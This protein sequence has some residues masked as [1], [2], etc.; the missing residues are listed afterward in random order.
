MWT[1]LLLMQDLPPLYHVQQVT[2]KLLEPFWRIW[3]LDLCCFALLLAAFNSCTLLALVY[4]SLCGVGMLVAGGGQG[5]RRWQRAAVLLLALLPIWQYAMLLGL[6]P[7]DLSPAKGGDDG[8]NGAL[9]DAGGFSGVM[10]LWH[11]LGVAYVQ[12]VSLGW[13]FVA[14]GCCWVQANQDEQQDGEEKDEPGISGLHN[15]QQQEH[16]HEQLQPL[17]QDTQTAA[18]LSAERGVPSL[19]DTTAAADE[20]A[21]IGISEAN[22]WCVGSKSSWSVANVLCYQLVKHSMDLLLVSEWTA[23]SSR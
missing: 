7:L 12:R 4:V 13:L 16:G 23:V 3:G 17:L 22:G 8:G 5:L 18:V 19:R 14:L 1:V 6:P 15:Q 21:P 10:L 11:W 20:D 9:E 2:Q